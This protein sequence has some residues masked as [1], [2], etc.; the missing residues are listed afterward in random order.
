MD[1]QHG[2]LRGMG[3]VEIV[4]ACGSPAWQPLGV[5]SSGDRAGLRG[6][7]LGKHGPDRAEE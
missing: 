5:R 1:P 6:G 4:N 3:L 7:N 2:R